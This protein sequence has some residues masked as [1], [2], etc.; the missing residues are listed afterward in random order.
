MY[1][2]RKMHLL[3]S[4]LMQS[5]V[6]NLA[7][8]IMTGLIRFVITKQDPTLPDMA[9]P[10][11]FFA[12]TTVAVLVILA[13]ALVFLRARRELIRDMHLVAEDDMKEMGRLQEEVF[14]GN[15]PSLPAE[16]IN[17]LMQIWAVILVGVRFINEINALLYRR[18]IM[19][20]AGVSHLWVT[21][22][23]NSTHGFKYLGML[24]AILLGTVM[25]GIF[26]GDRILKL[27]SAGLTGAFIICFVA[28]GMTVITV[29]SRQM[30]IVWTSVVFHL[31]DTLGLM[32]LAVYLRKQYKGL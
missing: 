22:L 28:I 6:V 16:S 27:V 26:L 19:S 20:M 4:A 30:G 9:D 24:T 14:G 18:F 3:S 10:V 32:I 17:R 25:T 31:T 8:M 11:I 5:A 2:S 13:T 1:F 21:L 15:L 12:Q 29:M 7:G 23:Y